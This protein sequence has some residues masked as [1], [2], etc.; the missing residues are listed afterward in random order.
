MNHSESP[1]T[2]QKLFDIKAA[3][4]AKNAPT[5]VK[6]AKP[7]PRNRDDLLYKTDED[8]PNKKIDEI[9]ERRNNE[10]R[11]RKAAEEEKRQ[12]E[13][14][15][16]KKKDRGKNEGKGKVT[17]GRGSDTPVTSK[18]VENKKRYQETNTDESGS[19]K[20]PKVEK[21]TKPFSELLKGV[22]FTISGIQNPDRADM[23]TMALEMGAKYKPDW[24]G[25]CTHLV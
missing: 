25:S 9:I 20:K 6:D 5:P 13:L 3:T 2:K 24:D 4:P 22:V 8:R 7:K 18:T 1:I 15:H 11:E 12:K 21:A 10:V 17:N 16:K 23:R 14:E 19:N